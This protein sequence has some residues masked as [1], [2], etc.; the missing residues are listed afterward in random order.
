MITNE[1][2]YK[3][4]KAALNKLDESIK[5]FDFQK[6]EK[7]SDS[8]TLAKAHLDALASERQILADEL[9]EYQ[10]LKSGAVGDFTAENLSELPALLVKARIAKGMSQRQLA[11]RLGIK[12]QQV[13]RYEAEKY[14]SASLR[15]LIEIAD[16]LDLHV[17]KRARFLKNSPRGQITEGDAKLNWMRFPIR[18]MYRKGWFV[19][20][21]GS[22]HEAEAEAENLVSEYL[23]AIGDRTLHAF[24]RKHVRSGSALDDYALLAWELRVLWLAAREQVTASFLKSKLTT[25]WI[26][27]LTKLSAEKNGAV[28]AQQYL[29]R[30]GIILIIEPHLSRTYVDGAALSLS[31]DKPVIGMTLRYDRI[32]NFW[33]VLLHEIAHLR[34][35]FRHSDFQ[36]FF[37]DLDAGADELETEADS[38]A[39]EALV[40]A[41]V[42][43][44]AVARYLRTSDS[45]KQLA[46]ELSISPALVAGR[47]R[48]EANNYVILNEL[49][50]LGLVRLQF[51][52]VKF[53]Q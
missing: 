11:D 7:A 41:T 24:H 39:S 43:E 25:E 40:P 12:E 38:F 22:E 2:Q 29:R 23:K 36:Q 47:I 42:W 13:Q 15:R 32:D 4:T 5:A 30:V 27:G 1:R 46:R 33:F 19:G 28:L 52:E 9:N 48:K 34:L 51:P 8:K 44:T 6:G 14:G 18:E 17:S 31:T 53:G 3:I 45:V 49:I 37:D 16:G 20:F 10:V 35:H 50:G 21:T 26:R